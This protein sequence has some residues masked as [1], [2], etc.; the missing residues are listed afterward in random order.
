MVAWSVL[1]NTQRGME[2]EESKRTA[3]ALLFLTIFFYVP[4]Y[5]VSRV[6]VPVFGLYET[7]RLKM[8]NDQSISRQK[9]ISKIAAFGQSYKDRPVTLENF[10]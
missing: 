4:L 2:S 7:D 9:S 6:E 3:S 10:I 1:C 8:I 5:A